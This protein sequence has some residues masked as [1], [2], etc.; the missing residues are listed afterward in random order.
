[1][2]PLSLV[3]QCILPKIWP[4]FRSGKWSHT[5]STVYYSWKCFSSV[6][7]SHSV[8]S[9]SLWPRGLH[10]ARLP[11][12]SPT[13]RACSNSCSSS[14]CC[15]TTISSS[16]VPFSCLQS[17]PASGSFPM[18]HIFLSGGE[19]IGASTPVL[20]M[21]IQD[22]FLL[23][24]TDLTPLQ[25]KGLSRVFSNTSKASFFGVRFLYYPTLTSIHD[26]WKNHGFD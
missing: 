17:S 3:Q 1:M 14:R 4:F 7:F 19:N 20:Q 16:V 6:Q 15:H 2:F 24:L 22:W 23:G 8:M 9:D 5:H 10:Q 18:S 13:P 12:P 21:N 25:S 11:C 26:Y